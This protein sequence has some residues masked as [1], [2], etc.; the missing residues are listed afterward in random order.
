MIVVTC[1]RIEV[2]EVQK[3]NIIGQR[4]GRLVAIAPT[5][6]RKRGSV[7]WIC[8]CDCGKEVLMSLSV[9]Q[10]KTTKSCGCLRKENAAKRA[11]TGDN[12]RVHGMK[13][14][15]IYRTWQG[16]KKRCF[17]PHEKSYKDY[18]GRGITVCDEWQNSF[19]TF[20]EW[21]MDNGYADNLTIDRIDVNGNYEPSNCRWATMA[22]QN[23]NKRR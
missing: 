2:I 19:E 18:G 15:K 20:Y 6:A 22:E 16:M 9:I 14:T 10:C 17:N 7:V 12:G 3:K 8:K 11:K 5:A 13:G 23:K 21:A 1:G 4:F